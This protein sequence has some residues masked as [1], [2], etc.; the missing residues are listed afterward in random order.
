MVTK[1]N[2]PFDSYNSLYKTDYGFGYISG[3]SID[4]FFQ[5]STDLWHASIESCGN[6]TL[7][8]FFSNRMAMKFKR[9]YTMKDL[10]N[11]IHMKKW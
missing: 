9:N 2:P 11:F 1:V 3:T 7:K 4:E 6:F 10:S 5:V 8:F